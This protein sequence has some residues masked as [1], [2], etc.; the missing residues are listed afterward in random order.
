MIHNH[1]IVKKRQPL[2]SASVL[3]TRRIQARRLVLVPTFALA[4][5]D[6]QECKPRIANNVLEMIQ[7]IL[8]R[9]DGPNYSELCRVYMH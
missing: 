5:R 1:A 4:N 3:E 2:Q 7:S 9:M 6:C 8:T